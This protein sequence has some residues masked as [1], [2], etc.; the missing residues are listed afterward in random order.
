[1]ELQRIEREA[2]QLI[3]A[4]HMLLAHANA[5]AVAS[6]PKAPNLRAA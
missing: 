6:K 1:N 5:V 3:G 4:V 2:G